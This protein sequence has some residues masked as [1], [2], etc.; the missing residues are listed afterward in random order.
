M[1]GSKDSFLAQ[2]VYEQIR[3]QIQTG[4]LP[5]GSRLVNRKLATELGTSMVPVREALNR[6]TSEG[7]LEHLPGGGNFVRK[8]N[9]KEIVQLY[10]FRE[11][12]EVFAAREAA[13][14]IQSYHLKHLKRLCADWE[15]LLVDIQKTE[16][17]ETTEAMLR[18]WLDDDFEFHSVIVEAADNSWLGKVAMD[19]K[20]MTLVIRNKPE[21][22]SYDAAKLTHDDHLML[23]DAFEKHDADQAERVMSKHI[24]Q[25]VEFILANRI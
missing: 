6:L 23:V 16:K 9:R 5:P 13:K 19:L 11:S 18:K 4:K 14:N 7:L 3:E 17:G 21:M 22:L 8:L 1:A 24:R 2:R 20:L 12:L 25:G 15:K 10:E